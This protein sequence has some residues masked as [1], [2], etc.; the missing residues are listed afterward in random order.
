MCSGLAGGWVT[1]ALAQRLYKDACTW[2]LYFL[3]LLKA[4]ATP[5][6]GSGVRALSSLGK[7]PHFHFCSIIFLYAFWAIPVRLQHLSCLRLPFWVQGIMQEPLRPEENWSDS[8]LPSVCSPCLVCRCAPHLGLLLGSV[9]DGTVSS[10]QGMRLHLHLL[11][12]GVLG[13]ANLGGQSWV[14]VAGSKLHA[15]LNGAQPLEPSSGG[16]RSQC[17]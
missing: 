6:P 17:Q 4:V 7:A 15:A 16:C 13:D 5:P 11:L 9:V 2:P 14:V 10:S 8:K 12:P 1:P 3:H